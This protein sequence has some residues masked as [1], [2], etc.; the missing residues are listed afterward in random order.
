MLEKYKD[1]FGRP[2]EGIHKHVLGVAIA[3]VGLTIIGSKVIA[4]FF[5]WDLY[6]VLLASFATGIIV[7]KAF[8]VQ[9]ALNKKLF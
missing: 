4:D 1:I 5:E 2:N 3:D 7:H 9:T 6:K 8:G